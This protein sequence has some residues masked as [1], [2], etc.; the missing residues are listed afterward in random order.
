MGDGGFYPRLIAGCP[1]LT[2]PSI[3]KHE[4]YM[5]A[6]TQMPAQ[7][8]HEVEAI[9]EWATLFI[10][11]ALAADLLGAKY[12]DWHARRVAIKSE[13]TLTAKYALSPRWTRARL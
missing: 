10:T 2:V 1:H 8:L 9:M 11:L 5:A 3:S 7:N 4:R 6:L 13:R 12:R